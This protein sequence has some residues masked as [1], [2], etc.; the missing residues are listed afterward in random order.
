M[1]NLIRSITG[2]FDK[3]LQIGLVLIIVALAGAFALSQ[4][5]LSNA[6]ESLTA[7]RAEVESLQDDVLSKQTTI[8][9]LEGV[10]KTLEQRQADWRRE[11][12]I[13]NDQL[14]EVLNA[15]D[16]ENQYP[17]DDVLCRAISGAKCVRND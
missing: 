16:E 7:A 2:F 15:P 11:R 5:R 17:L 3:Y 12:E 8:A 14:Q 4:W 9:L 1:G 13:Y 10:Q 6:N